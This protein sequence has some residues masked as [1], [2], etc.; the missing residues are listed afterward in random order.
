MIATV[1]DNRGSLEETAAYL[2]VPVGLVRAA[3]AYHGEY[4]D[5]I[6]ADIELN[7]A[8]YRRGFKT[9]AASEHAPRASEGSTG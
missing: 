6:D 4:R 3:V 5:E 8:A 1:R 9:A 7:E 2:E